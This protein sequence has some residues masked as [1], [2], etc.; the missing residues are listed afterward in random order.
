MTLLQQL[1]VFVVLY[2]GVYSLVDRI[3]KC[4]EHC[5][6][7]KEYRKLEEAKNLAK[8]RSKGE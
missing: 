5:V 1:I 2:I 4:V 6:S 3:C 8:D 7:A